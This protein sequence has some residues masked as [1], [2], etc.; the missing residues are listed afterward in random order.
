MGAH[1][2]K[3][4][5]DLIS[6]D[7][8]FLATLKELTEFKDALNEIFE[9]AVT[10]SEGHIIFA[11]D[12]F[13]KLSGYTRHELLGKTHQ[14][15]KSGEQGLAFYKNL[16]GTIIQ[17][18]VWHGEVKNLRKDGS[19]YWLD[20]IIVPVMGK[21][22]CPEKYIAIR[23]DITVLKEAQKN[24]QLQTEFTSIVSHELRTPLAAIQ[25]SVDLLLEGVVGETTEKQHSIL[26]ILKRNIHHLVQLTTSILDFSKIQMFGYTL[27]LSTLNL[28][29]LVYECIEQSMPLAVSKGIDLTYSLDPQCEE[30]PG[31]KEKVIQVLSNIIHNAIKFTSQGKVEVT[32]YMDKKQVVIAVRDQGPGISKEDL[33][34]LFQYFSQINKSEKADLKGLGLGLFISKKIMEL[35]GGVIDVQSEVGRG[36][37]FFIKFPRKK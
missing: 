24:A 11:N 36:S 6:S 15:L 2:K 23:K 1:A 7:Q 17:G 30:V 13:V 37:M 33:P 10:D 28:N 8:G 9:I 3:T 31:D 25:Q 5:P 18:K 34:K 4:H 35:H 32:S 16:W 27:S 19:Y 21:N 12:R 29:K 26:K 20:T 22:G 14:I